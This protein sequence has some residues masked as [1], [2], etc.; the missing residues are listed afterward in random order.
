MPK[1]GVCRGAGPEI[2]A[3]TVDCGTHGN[4]LW[5]LIFLL[6]L[7]SINILSVSVTSSNYF[8]PVCPKNIVVIRSGNQIKGK[9]EKN[10]IG[11]CD[12][13]CVDE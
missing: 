8:Q 1:G 5:Y 12:D 13:D 6:F 4:T 10:N 7:K 3:L 9:N 11:G 2:A